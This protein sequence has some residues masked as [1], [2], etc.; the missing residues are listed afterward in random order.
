MPQLPLLSNKVFKSTNFFLVAV[1]QSSPVRKAACQNQTCHSVSHQTH[2]WRRLVS[3]T[4]ILLVSQELS[5]PL[6]VALLLP[7]TSTAGTETPTQWM[8][9]VT[10]W[11]HLTLCTTHI[12]TV[13]QG[14]LTTLTLLSHSKVPNL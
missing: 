7:D 2:K 5:C 11:V 1:H 13:R 12:H 10:Q 3:Y 9:P 8:A 4:D 14:F 6:A